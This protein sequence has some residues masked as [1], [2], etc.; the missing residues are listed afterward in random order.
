MPF[1]IDRRRNPKQKSLG[2]R[3]RFIRRARALVK[4]A[5]NRSV[6]EKSI[7]DAGSGEQ[8]RIPT[9]GISEPRWR[10]AQSGGTRDMILP[11]NKEYQVGDKIKKPPAGGG[12]GGGSGKEASDQGDGEDG[13][14]FTLSREEFLDL[15]FEDLE[16]PDLVKTSLREVVQYK[17]HRAGF[18][19]AG[20]PTN[21]NV[22]RTMRNAL[23]RR[24]ALRRPKTDEED[25]LRAEIEALQAKDPRTPEEEERLAALQA[26][27]ETVAR[28][29]RTVPYIDPVDIRYNRFE[30]HPEPN[31]NAVMF[32]LMDVSGSM[33]EREKDLAKR[34]FVLL[35]LF[36]QRRY[37]RIDV[38]FVRHTHHAEEVDEHTFFYARE[39]GGTVVS[40]ALRK[41]QEIVRDRYNTSE[42]NIYC[43]QAS[44]GDDYSGDAGRCQSILT[45]ELMPLCQYYAYVE[46]I[47][48]RGLDELK[49]SPRGSVLWQ[50]YKPV[51]E[52][53]PNFAMKHIASPA[54]IYPV[55]RQLFAARNEPSVAAAQSSGATG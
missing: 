40:T 19:T 30:S 36:L 22:I 48:K 14:E 38:V 55:F 12:A 10:H 32:C 51:E 50:A 35:H 17:P 42:W 2:N 25:L 1:F 24:I 3:Q 29:L 53:W 46:I 37:E 43:A 33:G 34:F 11:G 18:A 28:R 41:M 26:L 13:F 27:L 44:D 8:V 54:D 21:L 9:K 45:E 4:D 15:F 5:V 20:T 52:A 6:T 16:L 47:D 31:S 39:T 49:S 23:G 7:T